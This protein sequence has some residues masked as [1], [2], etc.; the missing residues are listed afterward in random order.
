MPDESFITYE[1]RVL[2]DNEDGEFNLIA[3]AKD[4]NSCLDCLDRA[5]SYAQLK[6]FYIPSESSAE[7]RVY[8]DVIEYGVFIEPDVGPY[9]VNTRNMCQIVWSNKEPEVQDA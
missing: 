8:L 9:L 2:A 1:V 5:I 7:I 6:S 3:L 4:I